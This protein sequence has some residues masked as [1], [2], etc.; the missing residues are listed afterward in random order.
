M[1]VDV[2]SYAHGICVRQ[3]ALCIFCGIALVQ[4][5]QELLWRLCA[6]KVRVFVAYW[7]SVSF[8]AVEGYLRY[9][10]GMTSVYTTLLVIG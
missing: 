10:I 4:G 8:A 2:I 5:V 3:W 1:V 9:E 6:Y 7:R